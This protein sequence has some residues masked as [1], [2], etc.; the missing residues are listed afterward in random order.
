MK[1]IQFSSLASSSSGNSSLLRL[2]SALFL[3][4]SG[5]SFSRLSER[6]S[7]LGVSIED[8]DAVFLTHEH[9]DHTKGLS[10]LTRQR[11]IPVYSNSLTARILDDEIYSS[12]DWSIFQNES[13]FYVKDVE[14][15]AFPIPHDAVDPVGYTF[16]FN[17][18]KVSIVSDS[19]RITGKMRSYLHGTNFL[20]IEA[21]YDSNLLQDCGRPWWLKRRIDSAH[22]HLSNS[23]AVEITKILEPC[24]SCVVFGHLSEDCNSFECILK[25]LTKCYG[26]SFPFQALFAS[27]DAS[28]GWINME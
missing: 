16:Q 19:G 9:K 15:C 14:I 1:K 20:F 23:Q 2:G 3:I 26:E 10:L 12:V 17:Q 25:E 27:L 18:F 13:E 8:L 11:K 22:G 21:N 6:M 7:D 24:L 5:L 4:D 28:T